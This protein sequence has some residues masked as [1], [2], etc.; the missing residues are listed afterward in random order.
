MV[1]YEEWYIKTTLPEPPLLLKF[2]LLLPLVFI[3]RP[4]SIYRSSSTSFFLQY[5]VVSS[6]ARFDHLGSVVLLVPRGI[7]EEKWLRCPAATS[8]GSPGR[9]FRTLNNF[10]PSTQNLLRPCL[11]SHGGKKRRTIVKFQTQGEHEML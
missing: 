8:S 1:G 7:L 6:E 4:G 11:S 3:P 9:V 5:F 2:L 10:S